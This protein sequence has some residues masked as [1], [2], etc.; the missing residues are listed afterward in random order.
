[1]HLI[2]DT[3]RDLVYALRGFARQP[4]AAF[5]IVATVALGLGLVTVAFTLLN[6]FLFR[7][8]QVPDVHEMFA[9]ER[10]RTA[11]GEPRP[12]MRAQFNALRP[13]APVFAD[14]FAQVADVDGRLDARL[15]SGTFVSGNFFQV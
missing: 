7:V 2:H 8:D 11:D 5:T 9:V 15:M 13:E 10:P 3:A 14:A 6:T 12:F 1:M 4:L